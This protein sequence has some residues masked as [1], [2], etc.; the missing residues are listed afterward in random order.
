[1]Q[2]TDPIGFLSVQEIQ[3][4]AV[5]DNECISLAAQISKGFP[6]SRDK[7]PECLRYYWPMR[8]ELYVIDNVPFKG[9]KMLLPKELRRQVLEG[10]HAAHQGVA[11][12]LA[13]AGERFFWPGL[14]A[15]VKLVRSQCAKCV[16]NAP[17]QSTEPLILTPDPELPFQLTAIDLCDLEGN[18]FVVYA[19]RYTGWVEVAKLVNSTFRTVRKLLLK[20]FTTYGVPEEIASDGGPPFNSSEYNQFLIDGGSADDYRQHTM[21]RV[22]EEP[23]L[24]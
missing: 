14:H 19:D 11:G 12:M 1:L 23:K 22:M 15:A 24:Q 20:W 4:V 17:S 2:R 13:N 7:L 6:D 5:R 9:R 21:P 18:M 8:E 16:E 3:D 10:L